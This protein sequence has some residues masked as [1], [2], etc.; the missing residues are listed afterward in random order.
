MQGGLHVHLSISNL[1]TLFVPHPS[2]F[3]PHHSLSLRAKLPKEKEV[4]TFYQ[5]RVKQANAGGIKGACLSLEQPQNGGMV[6]DACV[7]QHA[8]HTNTRL[9]LCSRREEPELKGNGTV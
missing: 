3:S 8:G 6:G 9:C 1:L 7:T 4:C 2:P 5:V